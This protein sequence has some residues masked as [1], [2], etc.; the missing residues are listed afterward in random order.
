MPLFS[1]SGDNRSCLTINGYGTEELMCSACAQSCL[2]LCG[3]MDCS[4][5]SSMSGEFSRQEYSTSCH[6]QLPKIFPTQRPS[7]L[8]CTAGGFCSR[9]T[10]KDVPLLEESIL[11]PHWYI[12][13]YQ[14]EFKWVS[15]K[16]LQATN[17]GEGVENKE[18]SHTLG[19]VNRYSH[20][21]E[22]EW[23]FLKK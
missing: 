15:S 11:K 20:Y 19:N 17:A 10:T 5:P 13:S 12:S 23:D 9:W 22:Q 4:T 21:G 3:P 1:S 2:T 14:T 16:R 18:S 8:S 7:H 6:F